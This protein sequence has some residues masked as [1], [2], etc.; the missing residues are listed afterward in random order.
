MT[1]AIEKAIADGR[2]RARDGGRPRGVVGREGCRLIGFLVWMGIRD[3]GDEAAVDAVL[4]ANRFVVDLLERN[5]PDM[6]AQ[7]RE[8]TVRRRLELRRAAARAGRA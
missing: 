5:A 7:L 2:Y 1:P 4:R 6:H 3:A 8:R